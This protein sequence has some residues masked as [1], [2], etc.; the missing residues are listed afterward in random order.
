LAFSIGLMASSAKTH[1]TE[2]AVISTTSAKEALIEIVPLFERE[3]GDKLIMTYGSGPVLADKLR[4]GLAGDLFIGPDEFNKPL[5]KEGKLLDG[6]SVPFALSGSGV[7]V[8][9]GAPKP[10]ISTPEKFKAALLAAKSVSYSGGASGIQFVD[11]L[12]RLGIAD[13]VKAKLVQPKPGELV[14]SLV[15][16][17]GAEIGVQQFSELLPV[18]GIEI[19]GPL[20]GD[21]QKMNVYAISVMPTSTQREAGQAFALFMRSEAARAILEKKGLD[22]I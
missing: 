17:G 12:E 6:S 3:S 8:R 20:P 9:A 5:I 14:G 15:A 22:P 19:V 2:I 11:S 13:A 16:R 18:A 1:A 21:V 10:D 4:S 7:A